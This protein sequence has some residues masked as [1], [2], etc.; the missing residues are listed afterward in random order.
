MDVCICVFV[1]CVVLW[2]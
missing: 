2:R 1:C